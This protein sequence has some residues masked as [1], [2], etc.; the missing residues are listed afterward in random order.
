MGKYILKRL[1]W[2]IPIMFILSLIAFFLMYLSPGDPA[3][4]YLSQGGDAPNAEAL[5][6]L[7]EKLGLNQPI[8][9]QYLHWLGNVL[10]GNLG[11]SIFTGNPVTKEIASYFP[12]T[13]KLTLLSLVFTLAIS[14]PLGILAAVFENRWVDYIIRF[15]S[16]INGSMPGFFIS[17]LLILILGIRF[18]WFPTVSSGNPMGIWIPTFTLSIALSATYIRQIRNAIIEELGQEYIKMCKA[19]GIKPWSILFKGALKSTIPSIL[20]LAGINFG[21]LLGGTAIIEVV[22]SY[23]GIGRLAVYSI[24]NRDYPLM[25]GY[26]L[27]MAFIYVVVNLVVD[28]LH[29]FVDPRVKQRYISEGVKEHKKYVGGHKAL[30]FD[31]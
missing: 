1:L 29:A 5:A 24:T 22:C 17:M 18:K 6:I 14:I 28:I 10:S 25:Q 4:I 11:V 26:V 3:T 20:T 23:Q 9:V 19:R 13:L 16:F 7:R 21:A 31:K 30:E 2:L 12:N 27:V 8:W 15:L